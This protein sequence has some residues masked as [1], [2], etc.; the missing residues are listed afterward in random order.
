MATVG[1]S[2][3]YIALPSNQLIQL[4]GGLA[5]NEIDAVEKERK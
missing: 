2:S 5:Q 1:C 3:I 4:I